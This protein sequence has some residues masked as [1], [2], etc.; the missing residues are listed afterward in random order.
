M[1]NKKDYK[2]A[3]IAGF[4][5]GVFLLPS[6]KNMSIEDGIVVYGLPFV[7]PVLWVFGLWLGK[8]LSKWLPVIYQFAK[9]VVV[10]FLNTSIDFGVLNLLSM[11][12]GLTTGVLVGGVN[13]P[14]FTL[15]ATNSYFWN[16][17]WVFAHKREPGQKVD[18]SDFFTFVVVVIIGI[19][20][21]SGIVIFLT[22]CVDPLFNLSP[23]RW[24]N[25]AKVCATAISLIFNFL[26]FKFLVFRKKEKPLTQG[27]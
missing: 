4:I 18:Y 15:A 24:L 8:V 21:N 25:I 27:V 16:K 19:F 12:S 1:S 22:T 14:G 17:F 5:T 11:F 26:G 2:V 10:G 23:E 6:L 3:I 7:I 20:I 9:F 13:I